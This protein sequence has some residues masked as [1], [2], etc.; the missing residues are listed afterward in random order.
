[1]GSNSHSTIQMRRQQCIIPN[2][3]WNVYDL[4]SALRHGSQ[5]QMPVLESWKISKHISKIH[6]SSAQKLRLTI[7]AIHLRC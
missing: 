6:G 4:S 7:S 2:R 5:G 3:L 1:M